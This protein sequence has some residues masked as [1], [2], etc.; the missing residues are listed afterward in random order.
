MD[1]FNH[2]YVWFLLVATALPAAMRLGMPGQMAEITAERITDEKKRARHR[3][4]GWIS[5][6][7]SLVL[8]PVYIWWSQR[9][10]I[11]VA[12]IIGIVT[13][14]EMLGNAARPDKDS[15]RRQNVVFGL[16]YVACC[17]FTYFFAIHK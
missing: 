11:V 7:G 3:M 2:Y 13:G 12:F 4:W 9:Q 17:V 14:I 15:L 1:K 16:V 8:I 10:W 6:A 5:L